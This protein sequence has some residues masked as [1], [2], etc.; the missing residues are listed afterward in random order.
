MYEKKPNAADALMAD[1][2]AGA[3]RAAREQLSGPIQPSDLSR[4]LGDQTRSIKV[5]TDPVEGLKK[6]LSEK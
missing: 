2:L 1:L 5:P 6:L 4:L 3:E